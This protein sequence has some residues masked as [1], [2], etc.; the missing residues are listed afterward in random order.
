MSTADIPEDHWARP[1]L[2]LGLSEGLGPLV[3][4]LKNGAAP[5]DD[6]NLNDEAAA[7]IERLLADARML[8]DMLKNA[9][10]AICTREAQ[11][12]IGGTS[13]G[14]AAEA[15]HATRYLRA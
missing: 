2:G 8:R 3:E 4:R 13:C 9:Q 10:T 15:L 14:Q 7:Q 5:L 1:L 12:W 11:G 6:P